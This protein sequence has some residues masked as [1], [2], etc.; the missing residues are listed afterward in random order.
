VESVAFVASA[1]SP[2][3][4][5]ATFATTV[6]ALE[7]T[8]GFTDSE[9]ASIDTSS[10]APFPASAPATAAASATDAPEGER[11]KEAERKL[12]GDATNFSGGGS[13]Q[14]SSGCRSREKRVRM[15]CVSVLTALFWR[16]YV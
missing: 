6:V 4:S 11:R 2:T 8:P 12:G 9:D 7:D 15:M 3:P 5:A 1:A 13:Q 16:S 14:K 10:S